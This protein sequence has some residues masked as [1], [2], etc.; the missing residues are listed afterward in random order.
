MIISAS[1]S[2]SIMAKIS[3]FTL[4]FPACKAAN[5]NFSLSSSSFGSTQ[6]SYLTD[7]KCM[8]SAVFV[9]IG[10]ITETYCTPLFEFICLS[11]S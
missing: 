4:L 11:G 3:L 5:N 1:L 2:S 6:R 8:P 10:F 9:N 7:C